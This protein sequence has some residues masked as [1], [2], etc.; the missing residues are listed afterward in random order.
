ME[1]WLK[2]HEE[3]T[4]AGKPEEPISSSGKSV[5]SVVTFCRSV[6]SE[7]FKI[8]IYVWLLCTV[9]LLNAMSKKGKNPFQI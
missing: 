8:Y 7:N 6:C 2:Q 4:G 1:Q 9:R 5:V 3:A